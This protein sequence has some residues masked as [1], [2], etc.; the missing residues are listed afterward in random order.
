MNNLVLLQ[1]GLSDSH[2]DLLRG[3]EHGTL[4]DL[5]LSWYLQK[6]SP[7]LMRLRGSASAFFS[8]LLAYLVDISFPAAATPMTQDSPHPRWAT[9]KAVRITLTFPVQSKV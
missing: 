2:K 5:Q 3:V 6:V 1:I 8:R 9:S 7:L 4:P